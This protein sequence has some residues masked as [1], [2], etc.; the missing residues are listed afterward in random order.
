MKHGGEH[1]ISRPTCWM[2][3]NPIVKSFPYVHYSS[4]SM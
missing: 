4:Y 2:I 1:F 3:P